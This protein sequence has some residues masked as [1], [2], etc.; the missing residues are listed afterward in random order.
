MVL[1]MMLKVDYTIDELLD[2]AKSLE[3][4]SWL[5]YLVSKDPLY[6][7]F[8]K[9]FVE[10]MIVGTCQAASAMQEK[11]SELYGKRKAVEYAQL[12]NVDIVEVTDKIEFDY[13][14]MSTYTQEPAQITVYS[15][16]AQIVAQV[17][18]DSICDQGISATQFREVAI[19]HEL[20]H[21]MELNMPGIYTQQKLFSY[22]ALGILPRQVSPVSA[23]EVAAVQFSQLL[24]GIE[25]NPMIYELIIQFA[26]N[27]LL[28]REFFHKL[29]NS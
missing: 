21:H 10:T 2:G 23:S 29:A 9:E 4:V 6:A 17:M 25:Y 13:I 27:K 28:A 22:K 8:S 3:N 11:L 14:Y 16:A 5:R 15:S 1:K 18:E 24:T 26:R 19:A 7:K 20:F 12:L